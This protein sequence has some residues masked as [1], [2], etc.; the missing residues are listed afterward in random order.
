M[1]EGDGEPFVRT[2]KHHFRPGEWTLLVGESGSGKSSLFK[3]INRLWPHGR[4]AIIL[5]ESVRS[6]YAAQD[7]S[8]PAI[9]LKEL[10]CMPDPVDVHS[11]IE[12]AVALTKAGLAEFAGDLAQEGRNEHSWNQ[13]LSGGQKQKVVLAR[14]LLLQPGILYLDESTSAL[15]PDATVAF[16]QA[17]KDA[18]PTATVISIMHDATP[19]V[20]SAGKRFY[21]SVV[22]IADGSTRKEPLADSK[23]APVGP[24]RVRPVSM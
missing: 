2:A 23:G 14:I 18:C 13:L 20:S 9:S 15:D 7:V 10:I 17:I 16:H 21:D 6:L 12:V 22:T 5:P 4:G 11:D 24:A 3:A 8:L 1:H 19:P